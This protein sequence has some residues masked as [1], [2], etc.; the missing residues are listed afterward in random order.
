MVFEVGDLPAFASPPW[1]VGQRLCIKFGNF[2]F[3]GNIARQGHGFLPTPR[4]DLE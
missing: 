4:A 3:F 1:D 2:E